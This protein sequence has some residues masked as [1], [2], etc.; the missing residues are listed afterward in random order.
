MWG[1]GDPPTARQ[2]DAQARHAAHL[3]LRAYGKDADKLVP[4][5]ELNAKSA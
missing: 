3:F 2:K 4:R 1:V 5:D